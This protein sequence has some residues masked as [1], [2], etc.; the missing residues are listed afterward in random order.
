ML[1]AHCGYY[2][3]PQIDI[4]HRTVTERHS[5]TCTPDLFEAFPTDGVAVVSGDFTLARNAG[6]PVPVRAVVGRLPAGMRPVAE[7]LPCRDGRLAFLC[8][9]QRFEVLHCQ[10][11][12]LASVLAVVGIGKVLGLPS[13]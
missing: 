12:D 5:P 3:H 9:G 2:V 7:P 6:G 4:R 11:D 13:T 8:D 1:S 10:P